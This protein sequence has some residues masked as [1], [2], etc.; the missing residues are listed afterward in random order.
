MCERYVALAPEEPNSHD[1][2][3]LSYQ[4]AGRY[5][6]ALGEYNRALA[7]NPRFEVAAV[8]LAN[9]YFQLGRYRQ[10]IG[11]YQRYIHFAPSDLERARGYDC[12]HGFL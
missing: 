7:L 12:L 6:L 5:D 1:S 10:A 8:H 9:L 3:G 2:L 4:W 11:Q